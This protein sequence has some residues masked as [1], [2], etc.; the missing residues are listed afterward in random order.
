MNPDANMYLI[1]RRILRPLARLMLKRGIGYG[2]F[3]E[4][5]KTA[6]VEAAD[7][8]LGV[9]SKKQ[10]TSRIST[11]TGLSRKEVRRLQ[12]ESATDRGAALHK[13]NR[14]ARVLNG[15][16]TDH[17]YKNSNDQPADLAFEGGEYDFTSL[18]KEY[19]GDITARTI[20]DELSRIG[21]IERTENGLLRLIKQ[22]YIADQQDE[23]KLALFADNVAELMGTM[24]HNIE[25]TDQAQRRYQRKVVYDGIPI[26]K[27]KAL[28]EFIEARAQQC[29][30]EINQELAK[31]D[32]DQE[33][34]ASKDEFVKIGLGIH[35][36]EEGYK[37]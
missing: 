3:V 28:K 12:L 11:M 9:P 2:L 23:E 30:L 13:M 7:R 29:L 32:R 36:I 6:F 22:A 19:S 33:P 8:D 20:A 10:T 34:A 21:A 4:V 31:Y 1:I 26:E 17:H 37:E 27:R 14:A 15:W 24:E 18:V 5:A 16:L 25:Q 35:Y